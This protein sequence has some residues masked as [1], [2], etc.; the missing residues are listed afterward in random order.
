MHS[1]LYS[2]ETSAYCHWHIPETHYLEAWSD[3]RAYDGTV[4]ILQPLIAPLYEGKSSHEILAAFLGRGGEGT[5]DIVRN[6]WKA[7]KVTGDFEIFWRT[8][9][10]DGV[11][12]GTTF[13]PKAVKLKALANFDWSGSAQRL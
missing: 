6:Y 7:Q 11:V 3:V 13:Q 1:S 4:T 5:Y 10:H 8:A 2:D 12:S 9:L